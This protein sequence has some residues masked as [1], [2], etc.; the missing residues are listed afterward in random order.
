MTKE[1]I[2]TG[3][4][5]STSVNNHDNILEQA[6]QEGD[7]GSFED[8]NALSSLQPTKKVV[9]NKD[10]L[11]YFLLGFFT[12]IDYGY[13]FHP[14]FMNFIALPGFDM[15][16]TIL[17][18]IC[19]V[20][21]GTILV[22]FCLYKWRPEISASIL[23]GIELMGAIF[24]WCLPSIANNLAGYFFLILGS[25]GFHSTIY[26]LTFRHGSR[27]TTLFRSG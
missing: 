12:G 13:H 9:S 25:A 19:S 2:I 23:L 27:A 20:L 24:M 16:P 5:S 1:N 8:T 6:E 14:I 11:L 3:T 26:P 22:T 15:A 18:S 4:Q 21:V 10:T 7:R 17:V